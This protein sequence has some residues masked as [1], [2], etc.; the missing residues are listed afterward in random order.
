ME[1]TVKVYKFDKRTKAGK[2]LVGTY[3]FDRRD[4]EAMQREVAEL[5]LHHYPVNQYLINFYPAYKTVVSLMSGKEITIPTDTPA[6][7]DPSQEQY[8]TM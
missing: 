5:Q 1:Y 2:R 7:C 3:T 6:C 4:D 8:W